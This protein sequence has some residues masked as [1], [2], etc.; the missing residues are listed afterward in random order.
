MRG[1]LKAYK[2][3]QGEGMVKK[4]AK[5]SL[6]T[7]QMTA[8]AEFLLYLVLSISEKAN[9]LSKINRHTVEIYETL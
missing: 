7:L 3:L 2:S 6:C 1:S 5:S 4:L 9:K 8:N